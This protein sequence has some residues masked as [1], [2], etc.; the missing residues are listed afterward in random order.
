MASKVTFLD[1]LLAAYG[2]EVAGVRSL[3]R[4]FS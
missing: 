3:L 2:P 4:D 1:R